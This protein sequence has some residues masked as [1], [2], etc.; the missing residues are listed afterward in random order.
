MGMGTYIVETGS[1]E[2]ILVLVIT[3]TSPEISNL[4]RLDILH[5]E[6]GAIK[7]R[8]RNL[9]DRQRRSKIVEWLSHAWDGRDQR[10]ETDLPLVLCSWGSSSE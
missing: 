8:S 9:K 3:S 7:R 5:L 6:R 10:R 2:E 1:H 4:L